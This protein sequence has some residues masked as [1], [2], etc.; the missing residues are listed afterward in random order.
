MTQA[1]SGSTLVFEGHQR[2]RLCASAWGDRESEGVLFLHGGGQTRHAWGNAAARVAA[3]GRYCV[4]LD[5]RGH[6]ESE[7]APGGDYAL[8]SFVADAARVAEHFA[9]PPVVVGASLGGLTALLG[10]GEDRDLK[11]RAIVLVDVAPRLEPEG[12]SRILAFMQSNADGFESLEIAAECIAAYSTQRRRS[13]SARGLSRVLRRGE[14]GRWRWH[15]DPCF[16][17]EGGPQV[18]GDHARLLAAAARVAQPA[19]VVRG[20][21][22]DV[23]SEEGAREL[24]DALPDAEYAQVGGA[25]HMLAGDRNDAFTR[26]VLDFLER[27]V[28]A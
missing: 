6:G 8:E 13:V 26:A 7:W 9:R 5:L 21:E 18:I 17:G 19:L 1:D 4:S 2:L 16:I 25:G 27:R 15:W 22:S 28:P 3:S 24:L 12:T 23:L 14:D 10:S 20:R 11:A